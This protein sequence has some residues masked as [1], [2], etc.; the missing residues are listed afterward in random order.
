MIS[1]PQWRVFLLNRCRHFAQIG[2]G[3]PNW[4]KL[5]T[6]FRLTGLTIEYVRREPRGNGYDGFSRIRIASREATNRE[7][8]PDAP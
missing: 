6:R 2:S 1:L 5:F 3:L 8:D 7:R 4:H